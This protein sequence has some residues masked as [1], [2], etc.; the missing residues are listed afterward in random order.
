VNLRHRLQGASLRHKY[1][2]L[3]NLVI[4]VP[5]VAYLVA[6]TIMERRSILENRIEVLESMAD[7]LVE[8]IAN[9]PGPDLG[10][11]AA[12]LERFGRQH[13]QL[14]IMV[15][16]AQGVVMAS[17]KPERAGAGWHEPQIQLVLDGT[18][19]RSWGL[20]EHDGLPV[21]DLTL[22][23]PSFGGATAQA[24]HIAEPQERL[25][26]EILRTIVVDTLFLLLLM[27]LVTTMVN[28]I[29]Q[30]LIIRR[31]GGMADRIGRTEWLQD[32]TDELAGDELDT[33]GRALATMMRRIEHTTA[34]LR[35]TL[36]EKQELVDRVERFNEELAAQV[37]ATRAELEAVQD[38]LLRKERLSVLGELTAGLAHE[39]R[40]PLQI[41]RGTAELVRR[42]RP[43]EG[44]ALDDVIEE[45][46]RLELLVRELLDYARPLELHREPVELARLARQAAE[47]IEQVSRFTEIEIQVPAQLVAQADETLLRRVL[48]NLL[49]NAVEALP[50]SGGRVWLSGERLPDGGVQLLI[51]D[52][53]TGIAPE[54]R[55]RIFEPFFSRKEAGVGMGLPLS[56]RIVEQHGG[57]LQLEPRGPSGTTVRLILPAG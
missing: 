7:L 3:V 48:V 10:E 42:A 37:A 28:W 30:R 41:I 57:S 8:S 9:D 39:I 6:D 17:S 1:A 20:T 44:E 26:A 38:E 15:L 23:V 56:R 21:L 33:L 52:E 47:E 36:A 55:D 45:V 14:E 16:D 32:E 19:R 40:N 29:T 11:T 46:T 25:E 24:V 49:A 43:E 51:Q 18:E 13:P 35:T 53:G 4:L 31:L 5:M 2:P 22:P 34:D 50:S 54:D 27:L 12:L